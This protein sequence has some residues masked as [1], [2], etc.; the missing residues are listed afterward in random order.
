MLDII[1]FWVGRNDPLFRRTYLFLLLCRSCRLIA[2]VDQW[3]YILQWHRFIQKDRDPFP[4][5]EM[6]SRKI[7]LLLKQKVPV[8]KVIDLHIQDIREIVAHQS[9]SAPLHI[10]DKSKPLLI[11][12]MPED[13]II[14]VFSPKILRINTVFLPD[15]GTHL[16]SYCNHGTKL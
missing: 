8:Q 15:I 2:C 10:H 11:V 9:E 12:L 16:I 1:V 13:S 3:K 14:R 7:S 5:C 6:I 4:P